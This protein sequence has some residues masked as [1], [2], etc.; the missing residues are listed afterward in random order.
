MKNE[1]LKI[2]KIDLPLVLCYLALIVIGWLNIYSS[3]Y[4]EGDGSIFNFSQ[5]YGMQFVWMTTAII[6][7]ICILFVFNSKLYSVFSPVFY[8]GSCLLLISVIFLGKEINGSK[9]W[10][11][12]GPVSFQ[13][14]EIS[15]ICTS[16][17]LA[18]TIG[19][20]G[21]KANKIKDAI[22]TA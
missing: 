6:I 22:R 16:L 17:F 5:K 13:P 21:L 9:S 12:I 1:G 18:Y 19:K 7:A 15:K 14:A 3:L 8:L 11:V 20:Y 2:G 10:F 4:V